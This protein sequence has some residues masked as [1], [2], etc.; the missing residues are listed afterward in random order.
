MATTIKQTE[1]EPSAYPDVDFGSPGPE[2]TDSEMATVWERL[3][4][5]CAHRWAERDVEWVVEGCGE[6][7]PPLVPA[8]IDTVEVWSAGASEWEAVEL[9]A[10]PLGGYY[11]PASGPYRF[12]ATVGGGDVPPVV[13]EAFL[14]LA[15]YFTADHGERPGSRSETVNLG[16]QLSTTFE[17]SPQWLAMAMQNSGAADLL[18]P[19]RRA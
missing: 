14:R 3:E 19:Y 4:A 9:K 15:E 6:W 7:V 16:G 17:R 12:L 11:L 1:S 10:S 5:W 8:E 18:R 13:V 2:F